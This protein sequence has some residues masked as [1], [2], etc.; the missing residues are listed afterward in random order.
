VSR[1]DSVRLPIGL[2]QGG[3]VQ[4]QRGLLLRAD[5]L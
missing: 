5:M 3:A 2:E 1:I 4:G